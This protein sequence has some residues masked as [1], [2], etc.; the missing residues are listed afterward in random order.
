[1]RPGLGFGK[2]PLQHMLRNKNSM[3]EHHKSLTRRKEPCRRR[4]MRRCAVYWGS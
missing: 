4:Q 1:M 2:A 3:A